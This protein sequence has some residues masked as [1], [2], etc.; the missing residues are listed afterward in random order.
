MRPGEMR[1]AESADVS[2]L[3]VCSRSVRWTAAER[4][5]VGHGQAGQRR[6]HRAAGRRAVGA[7]H[8]RERP[9]DRPRAQHRRAVRLRSPRAQ[10]RT[11]RGPGRCGWNSTSSGST[12]TAGRWPTS[13]CRTVRW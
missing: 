1:R 2:G 12:T 3:H 13:F 6:R 10:R 5:R 9:G 4:S 8:R 11:G 7:L